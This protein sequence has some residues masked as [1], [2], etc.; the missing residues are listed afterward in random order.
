[1]KLPLVIGYGNPLRQDDG[2]GWRAAELLEQALPQGAVRIIETQQLTPELAAELEGA[3]I[4]VLLDSALDL[5]PGTVAAKRVSAENRMAWPH[6]LSAEQLAGLTEALTGLA[7]PVFQITGGIA[8]IGFGENL[9]P[10]GELSAKRM[11]T[12][13]LELLQEYTGARG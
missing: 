2:L 10:D 7:A 1:M 13:A 8:Q 9:T 4:V 5:E 6:D 12:A 3:P 11:A